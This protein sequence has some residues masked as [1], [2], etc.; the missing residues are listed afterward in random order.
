MKVYKG[1]GGKMD[2]N[3]RAL[4]NRSTSSF[5]ARARRYGSAE[6]YSKSPF[7]HRLFRNSFITL[8]LVNAYSVFLI[9]RFWSRFSIWVIFCVV[10]A[11]VGAIRLFWVVYSSHESLRLLFT[12]R[13]NDRRQSKIDYDMLLGLVAGISNWTLILGLATVVALLLALFGELIRR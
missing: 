8:I 10:I 3:G 5:A 6:F 4:N 9:A 1:E 13:A 2:E 7:R 12:E 11:L